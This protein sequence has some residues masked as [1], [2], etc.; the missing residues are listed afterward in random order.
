L[1]VDS[2][3]T[4]ILP[5]TDK[6]YLANLA[7][8]KSKL[9]AP[10]QT[11]W[12]TIDDNWIPLYGTYGYTPEMMAS[13]I[14]EYY[15]IAAAEQQC[16]GLVGYMWPGGFDYP[17][18]LGVRDMPQNAKDLNVKIGR[19]IN[20]NNTLCPDNESPTTPTN[21]TVSKITQTSCFVSWTNSKD[22]KRVEYYEVYKDGAFAGSTKRSSLSV[23]GLTC[24]TKYTLA[25]IATD[26]V[27][28]RSVES[29]I[30]VTTSACEAGTLPK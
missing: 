13:V 2:K 6:S 24:N 5:A 10:H 8:L 1:L 27:G 12:L 30:P 22:N 17:E 7:T 20:A 29:A 21:F 11:I 3:I 25:I 15:D 26:A 14:Q 4:G 9:S 19:M 23:S 18:Q 16:A 28:N